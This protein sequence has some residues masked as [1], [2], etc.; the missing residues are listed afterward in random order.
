MA[1]FLGKSSVEVSNP[2]VNGAVQ[3]LG[4]D[5]LN[6]FG[7]VGKAAETYN[8]IGETA[9]KLEASEDARQYQEQVN[10]LTSSLVYANDDPS[11][12]SAVKS[13]INELSTEFVTK[14]DK[15]KNHKAAYETY[16]RYSLD[17][18]AE[19]QMQFEPIFSKGYLA[20]SIKQSDRDIT[21]KANTAG[22]IPTKELLSISKQKGSL[23]GQD[24]Y[25]SE[26]LVANPNL[27]AIDSKVKGSSIE[28]IAS[29][30]LTA[31]KFD[32]VKGAMYLN[33][34]TGS[35]VTYNVDDKGNVSLTSDISSQK[36]REEYLDRFR[37]LRSTFTKKTNEEN[38]DIKV[39][40]S[41]TSP[42]PITL[43]TYEDNKA[44]ITKLVKHIGIYENS[45]GKQIQSI[46]DSQT[47][48]NEK[49]TAENLNAKNEALYSAL[50][51]GKNLNEV[52]YQPYEAYNNN[53]ES[54]EVVK[55][56]KP[57]PISETDRKSF[58]TAYTASIESKFGALEAVDPSIF[59]S[60][61]KTDK[62][63][64]NTFV[65]SLKNAANGIGSISSLDSAKNLQKNLELFVSDIST[66][67]SPLE[68]DIFSDI[69]GVIKTKI[70]SA[71]REK[72]P[73]N[74]SEALTEI[75]STFK[76][77]NPAIIRASEITDRY[78]EKIIVDK[79]DINGLFNNVTPSKEV[80]LAALNALTTSNRP[81]PS[82]TDLG[83]FLSDNAINTTR[84]FSRER[85]LSETMLIAP[86]DSNGN[87]IDPTEMV[88]G[89]IQVLTNEGKK[90]ENF[91]VENDT[92]VG[93]NNSIIVR[94]K[95]T[96]AVVYTLT[97]DYFNKL[98]SHNINSGKG[99][100]ASTSQGA[101]L[102]NAPS[103]TQGSSI[104]RKR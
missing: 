70:D 68:K 78:I 79:T 104:G 57:S 59:K 100:R 41:S 61:I 32:P 89:I 25:H 27:D 38:V 101:R 64:F 74:A 47:Y 35:L 4:A 21:D 40:K 82:A 29:K 88:N 73:K 99:R 66:P 16:N 51:N 48:A 94:D 97:G 65:G 62:G 14:A 53:N 30:I 10:T 37:T 5:L 71:Y 69:A 2:A 22:I 34:M 18:T 43:G 17:I 50:L 96:N 12:Y 76:G 44:N 60:V 58:V 55:S 8:T 26:S 92:M 77:L 7:G 11:V 80:V 31:N 63:A 46:T 75:T 13:R 54:V 56:A 1:D 36:I 42:I 6:M 93:Y 24:V 81:N 45:V 33:S 49:I 9:A 90:P 95:N 102:K 23:Y 103:T 91:I 86:T 98:A 20:S 67:L 3:N 52:T 72:D 15:F 19:T 87:R 39:L 83:A 28:D 85:G 84:W